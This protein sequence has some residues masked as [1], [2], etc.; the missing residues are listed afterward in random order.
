MIFNSIEFLIFALLFFILWP[1]VRKKNNSRWGF[2]VASSFIF[3][4]WWDWRFLFLIIFSGMID[5]IAGLSMINMRKMKKV[6]QKHGS[7]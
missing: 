6:T 2:I 4:G 3:Y 1:L 7:E 5:Y